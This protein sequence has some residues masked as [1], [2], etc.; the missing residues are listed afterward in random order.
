[1]IAYLFLSKEQ[2]DS[3]SAALKTPCLELVLAVIDMLFLLLSTQR[4]SFSLFSLTIT[5]NIFVV[6]F[7]VTVVHLMVT[8]K[9]LCK[10]LAAQEEQTTLNTYIYTNG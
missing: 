2:L 7:M 1:M 8:T 4:C 5:V 10:P 3:I 9:A 6:V